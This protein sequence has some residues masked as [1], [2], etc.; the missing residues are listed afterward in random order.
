MAAYLIANVEVTNPEDYREYLIRNTDLVTR[1]G[2]HFVVRGGKVDL[3]EGEWTTYRVVLIEF[4]DGGAARA[5]YNSR[6]YQEVAEIR[7][8]NAR[9]HLLAIVESA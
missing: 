1:F 8:K 7:R 2:G 9:T 3:L 5:W 4:P 6:D